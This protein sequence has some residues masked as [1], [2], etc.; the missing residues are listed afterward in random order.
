MARSFESLR[1]QVVISLTQ[2]EH[3]P[4]RP[5]CRLSGDKLSYFR[6]LAL[7]VHIIAHLQ[8][9]QSDVKR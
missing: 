4:V 3:S 9:S 1:G 5:A 2:S 8:R 7:G 6:E